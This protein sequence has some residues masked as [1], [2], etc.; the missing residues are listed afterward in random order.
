MGNSL[1][2]LLASLLLLAWAGGA[3]AADDDTVEVELLNA[4]NEPLRCVT[5]L[6]HF[7]SLPAQEVAAGETLV[8]SYFR[9][10]DDGTLYV[11]RD[12][13]RRMMIENVICGAAGD[14]DDSRGEVPLLTIRSAA[15]RHVALSCR[16][17]ERLECQEN[18]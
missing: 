12:D 6:A 15:G 5:V 17:T 18:G 10:R 1:R 7:V 9:G 8:L 13:G 16:V 11:L 3:G 2:P 14:W 4:G